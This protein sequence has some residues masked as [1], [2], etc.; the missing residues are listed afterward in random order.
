M[1]ALVSQGLAVTL[2]PRLVADALDGIE[3]RPIDGPGP[4]RDVYA[5][6]PPGGRHP[7]AEPMVAALADVASQL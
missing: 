6:L 3:L 1:R 2:V 5:M 7:L 4:E